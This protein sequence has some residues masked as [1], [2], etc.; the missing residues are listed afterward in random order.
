MILSDSDIRQEIAKKHLLI[1]PFDSSLLQ[2][3]SYDLRLGKEFKVFK[4]IHKAYFD[5]KQNNV[6]EFMELIRIKDGNPLI[7]HPGE[8]ILGRTIE[9]VGIPPDL[10]GRLE[11]KSS[12]GRLGIIVHATA[13]FV[14]PG[15]KGTLTLEMSNIA[16]IPIALYPGMKVAQISFMRMETPCEVPYGKVRGSKYWGQ[17]RP[18]GSRIIL[19]FKK[20]LT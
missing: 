5:V 7:V 19:D 18:T 2:P 10:I 15:F 16:N 9:V 4:S 14:D 6:E 20:N 13:G 1:S 8:F 12:L 17:I 11:G 3:A